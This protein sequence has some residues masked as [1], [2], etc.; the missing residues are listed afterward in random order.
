MKASERDDINLVQLYNIRYCREESYK[1][2][3]EFELLI[4]FSSDS[5]DL[6]V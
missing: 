3:K 6:A 2:E 5:I 1:P 4:D